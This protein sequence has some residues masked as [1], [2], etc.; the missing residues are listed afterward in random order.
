MPQ[1][2]LQGFAAFAHPDLVYDDP[3]MSR[4][5]SVH[6]HLVRRLTEVYRAPAV[7]VVGDFEIPVT[8]Y[9]DASKFEA[10]RKLLR[11]LPI[12]LAHVSQLASP[13]S[14][15]VHD[16]LGVPII[17]TRNRQGELHAM[18]NVCR[19][20]GARLLEQEGFCQVRKGFRCHYHGWTYDTD[21]KL[22]HVP[23]EGLFSSLDKETRPLVALPVQ[24]RFGL[25]WVVAT[26]GAQ[27]DFD[28]FLD[29]LEDDLA[30][31]GLGSHVV[32]RRATTTRRTNWKILMEAFLDSYHVE[33]LHK[34][35][36]A[37]YFLGNR[38]YTEQAGPHV[39]SI[40]GRTGFA[41]AVESGH[42]EEIR[43]IATPT[44][45]IFPSTIF[46]VQPGFVSR[47]T[48]YPT[49]IDEIYWEH[50]LIIPEEPQTEKAKAHWEL[51]FE[52]IQNGVF[53]GEDLWICEQIQRG[54]S[55]GAN[56]HLTYGTEE[57]PIRW[58]HEELE[59][60]LRA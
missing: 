30:P 26:P 9:T 21:G 8:V 15:L 3:H 7:P 16:A 43:D 35:T 52:L 20:R 18:L 36:V 53:S 49:A 41:E 50:D 12:P 25:I 13:G 28:S 51:N 45:V 27:Y 60:R 37:P 31:L 17:V 24:E 54:L 44:Y 29:P 23:N 42:V 32:F 5:P 34:K 10:E 6:R 11:Q 4:N 48:A 1:V 40:V 46:V 38:S 19:H 14:C 22:V 56:E 2:C 57:A 55:S 58:W 33:H 39:R 59:R 47:A